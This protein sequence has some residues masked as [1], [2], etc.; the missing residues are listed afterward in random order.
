MKVPDT[1]E[2]IIGEFVSIHQLQGYQKILTDPSYYNQIINFTFP[3]VGIV[4]TNIKDYESDKIYASGCI[5]NNEIS[6][7]SNYRSEN[8]L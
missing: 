7:A 2:I 3:H 4:G 5:I 1:L 8:R 6:H